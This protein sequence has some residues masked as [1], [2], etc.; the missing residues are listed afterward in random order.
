MKAIAKQARFKVE[1][2]NDLFGQLL[3][4]GLQDPAKYD[5]VAS[6]FTITQEREEYVDFSDPYWDGGL[7]TPWPGDSWDWD[8]GP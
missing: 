4:P 1:F 7:C 3:I 5:M 6:G 2:Q 8:Y